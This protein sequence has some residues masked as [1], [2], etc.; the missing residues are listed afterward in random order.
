MSLRKL[1]KGEKLSLALSEMA[2]DD[3]LEVQY[4]YYSD[5]SIRSA[6]TKAQRDFTP[7]KFSV[8]RK[9]AVKAVVTR[10]E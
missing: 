10:Y 3:I 5:P 1:K 6:V 8:N 7:R 9:G 2:L 4:M